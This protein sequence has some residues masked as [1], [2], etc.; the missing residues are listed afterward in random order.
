MTTGDRSARV[1]VVDDDRGIRE[2]VRT[3]LA[4][5]G[6]DVA[7][8]TDGQQALLGKPSQLDDLL[9]LVEQHAGPPPA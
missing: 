5:E 2:F 6:Y 3:V 9:R 8:A 1:L 7:E 4:D